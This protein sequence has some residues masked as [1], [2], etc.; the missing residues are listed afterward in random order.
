[1]P[2]HR[3]DK[4]LFGH[5][6]VWTGRDI[7]ALIGERATGGARAADLDVNPLGNRERT[8]WLNETDAQRA[9]IVLRYRLFT[10][11][12]DEMVTM[13]SLAQM[14]PGQGDLDPRMYQ[15]GGLWVYPVG[16]LLRVAGACG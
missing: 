14:H 13:M 2:S 12:P 10:Y 9:E 16:A 7:Q 5:H 8:V 11:H 4:Y 15:Y 3:V 1:L 6:P